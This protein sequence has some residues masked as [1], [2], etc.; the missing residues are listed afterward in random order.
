LEAW[1]A[2]EVLGKR[3]G[4]DG[5]TKYLLRWQSTAE[6]DSM[7]VSL[8][9]CAGRGARFLVDDYERQLPQLHD[10]TFAVVNSSHHHVACEKEAALAAPAVVA[11]RPLEEE[12]LRTQMAVLWF[13]C[14]LLP[15]A[16]G[17]LLLWKEQSK[18]LRLCGFCLRP[19]A[20]NKIC[21]LRWIHS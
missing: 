8:P 9:Q 21:G 18:L 1:K 10:E 12:L 13:T 3:V 19:T 6:E 2:D 14:P 4:P 15:S 16:V 7:W 20:K 17:R 5:M 11:P